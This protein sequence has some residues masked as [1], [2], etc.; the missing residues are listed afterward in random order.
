M[1]TIAFYGFCNGKK[2]TIA[3]AAESNGFFEFKMD[4]ISDGNFRRVKASLRNASST[5]LVFHRAFLRVT[6]PPGPYEVFSQYNRWSKEDNGR[7]ALLNGQGV[8][9]GHLH[10]RTTEGN[11]PFCAI[12]QPSHEEGVAF[13]LYPVG[14]WRIR[15]VPLVNS[16]KEP[17]VAV[18]LGISDE[19]LAFQLQPGETWNLPEILIHN[20]SSFEESMSDL[21]RYLLKDPQ[22]S[23]RRL[24]VVF[25]TWF[26][27]FDRLNMPHLDESLAAA[28]EIGCETFVVDA[29][30][31]GGEIPGWFE[32]IGNWHEKTKLA[33]QGRMKEFSDKVREAG[34]NF[35]IWMEPER[36]HPDIAVVQEHPE[37]FV[38]IP[39][40][41]FMRFKLE[42]PEA[43][44]YFEN[45]I[46]R[47][48]S[49]YELAYM[50]T[51]MNAELGSDD[52]GSELYH[53][54][55]IFYSIV[56]R[57][58]KRHPDFI[59]ENCASGALRTDLESLRHFDVLFPSDNVNPWTLFDT[60]HGLWRRAL[61]GRIMRW[62]TICEWKEGIP[63]FENQR[64]AIVIPGE[65]T[66][67]EYEC[68]D[69]ESVL[70][71][72]FTGGLYGF[73][74]DIASLGSASRK[75][76]AR[77]IARFKRKREFM[78]QAAGHWLQD[79]SRFKVIELEHNNEA[80]LEVFYHPSDA[81]S[82][83]IIRPVGLHPDAFYSVAQK[84][85]TGAKL[86]QDGLSVTLEQ[87]MH[88]KWRAIMILLEPQHD[89]PTETRETPPCSK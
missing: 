88:L 6:L 83:R 56:D 39:E 4:I 64:P 9:L 12:K 46:E 10:G 60:I 36:I 81:V 67:E 37:W 5:P 15:I 27:R 11:T 73:S 89:L 40:T 26:D 34:L 3:S 70:I 52:S 21:H 18:D 53:Y 48:I 1:D 32:C 50:K 31:F 29:G 63:F 80:I 74:G 78:M 28:K 57:I 72:N 25:N 2:Y 45:E 87:N 8:L 19:E 49:T 41:G 69:L 17:S 23:Q 68:A 35:G 66:W 44:T 33:F 22:I 86:M 62:I 65:A 77:Y 82:E 79:D 13:H 51:D 58:R 42:N 30:W 55:S 54:Q 76:V 75:L 84:T 59:L 43:A 47:L 7:W 14:N 61:P 24:P 20:F 85:I 71:A 38:F 16:N